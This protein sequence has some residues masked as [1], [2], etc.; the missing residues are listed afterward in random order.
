MAFFVADRHTMADTI[1]MVAATT[2]IFI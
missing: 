2:A 1:I